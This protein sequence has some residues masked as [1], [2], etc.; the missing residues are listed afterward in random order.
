MRLIITLLLLLTS[1]PA[2]AQ[3]KYFEEPQATTRAVPTTSPVGLPDSA[4]KPLLLSPWTSYRLSVCPELGY[5]LTGT[6]SIR[7]Y[8]YQR[9]L[10]R[11][12][13]RPELDQPITL[14]GNVVNMCQVY[15]MKIDVRQG[16]L[17]PATIGVG[18]TGGT[19]VIVRVDPDNF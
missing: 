11:W 5:A 10:S 13:Y 9:G 6:G 15:G 2:L 17:L 12:G 1:V 18:M 16:Y 3:N 8:V 4:T 7:L 19:T 14:V